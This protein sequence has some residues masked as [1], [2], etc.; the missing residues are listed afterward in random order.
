MTEQDENAPTE[1]L[2]AIDADEPTPQPVDPVVLAEHIL[3]RISVAASEDEYRELRDQLWTIGDPAIP[4]MRAALSASSVRQRCASACNLGRMGDAGSLDD[5]VALLRDPSSKVREMAIFGLGVMGRKEAIKPLLNSFNDYDADVRYRVLI[6]L[7]DLN[8]GQIE[9]I[10]IRGMSDDSYGVREQALSTLRETATPA[11]LPALMLGI[12]DAEHKMQLLAEVTLDRVLP[13]CNEAHYALLRDRLTPRQARLVMNYLEG[14]NLH[15]VWPALHGQ[16]AALV[17]KGGTAPRLDKYGR[18]LSDPDEFAQL[19]HAFM[20]E[21]TVSLLLDHFT[22]AETHRSLLL[23]GPSGSGKTAI[24]HEFARRLFQ[25]NPA[26]VVLET[27][28]SELMTGTRY[29]GDWETKLKEMVET[30]TAHGKVILYVTNPNDLLG[31]GAHSKSNESFADFFKPYLQRG[32]VRMVAETTQDGLKGGLNRDPGLLRLFKKVRIEAMGDEETCQVMVELLPHLTARGDRPVLADPNVLADITDYA[33]SFLTRSELPGGAVD[34]LQAIVEQ[35]GRT[36]RGQPEIATLEL[37][38]RD[39]PSTLAELTDIDLALVDDDVNLPLDDWHSWFTDRMVEQNAAIDTL[40]GHLALIK[41]GLRDPAR[42][43]A[44]LFLVGPTGVGKT[45][46]AKLLAERMFGDARRMVRFDL[47]EYQG[48]YAVEKLIGSPHDKDRDGLL[49]DAVIEQP[50]C[51]LLLDE[52]EKADPEVYHLF[53]QVLDEG[54]L[55]DARGRTADFRQ[56]IILMTSNLGSSRIS[57]VPLGFESASSGGLA[58][59]IRKQ[60]EQVFQPEFINR[61]DDVVVFTPLALT[62]IRRLVDLEV[63]RLAD[64][65]GIRRYGLQIELTGESRDWL[66]TRGF[67]PRFGARELKRCL[68]REVLTRISEAIVR[69]GR[70]AHG[71]RAQVRVVDDQLDVQLEPAA[72]PARAAA[73]D[74]PRKGRKSKAAVSP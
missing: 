22:D 61:L 59:N 41:A 23:V 58:G 74:P 14:R 36:L 47:S 20:R 13:H 3:E 12:L 71:T 56:T 57:V 66:A 50:Y 4:V 46:F 62:S 40:M 11:A 48:R 64:R 27:N 29:L 53:L 21:D 7:K 10:L 39:V 5:L 52:F 26:V 24:I 44:T 67:S 37:V 18:N 17:G 55:T 33:R 19:H 65:R 15:E 73:V 35:K 43:M 34:L 63:A 9:P 2:G 70:P 45:Y 69:H 38:E 6:A 42:P 25:I 60:M 68:E 16:L 72:D 32:D 8:Y 54:R 51:V 30:L 31:A 1:E 28:T 49:T